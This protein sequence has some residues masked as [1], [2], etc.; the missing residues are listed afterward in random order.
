MPAHNARFA[1]AAAEPGSAFVPY[2]GELA[3]VLCG[4]A[5][6]VAGNDNCVRYHGRY[7]QIPPHRHRHHFVK[8]KGRVHAYADGRLAIFHGPR[9]LARYGPDGSPPEQLP[10][11]CAA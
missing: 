5:E 10:T 9:C 8:V 2:A 11:P 7:L 6:R 4:Q 3:E 1:I